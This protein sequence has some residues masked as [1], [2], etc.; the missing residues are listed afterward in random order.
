LIEQPAIIAAPILPVSSP[1]NIHAGH[2]HSS[3]VV[4]YGPEQGHHYG[5]GYGYEPFFSPSR[6][7]K[8]RAL[9]YDRTLFRRDIPKPSTKPRK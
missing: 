6:I 1:Y 3:P 4:P 8:K 2:H 5:G 7:S 9:L